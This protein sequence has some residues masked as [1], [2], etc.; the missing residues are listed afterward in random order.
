ME[1][2]DEEQLEDF[3]KSVKSGNR[4]LSNLDTGTIAAKLALA[5]Q[6]SIDTHTLVKL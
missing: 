3:V 1:A 6:K 4:P 5:A 2:G